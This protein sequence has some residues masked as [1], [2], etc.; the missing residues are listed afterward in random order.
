MPADLTNQFISDHYHSLLHIGSLNL[1]ASGIQTVYDGDGNSTAIQLDDNGQTVII[2]N[3]TLMKAPT[4]GGPPVDILDIIYPVG[5]ILMDVTNSNPGDRPGFENTTWV[6][7]G[8]GRLVAG[9]TGSVNENM[10]GNNAFTIPLEAMPN[11]DHGL[12]QGSVR[13]PWILYVSLESRGDFL[14]DV[15]SNGSDKAF[16]K[17]GVVSTNKPYAEGGNAQINLDGVY[18]KY[19]VYMWKRTV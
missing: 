3:I 13:H 12:T 8:D 10:G 4:G 17:D 9:V 7:V 18:K 2:N 6:S 19:G 16:T 15:K 14:D 11:H 5:S 1:A